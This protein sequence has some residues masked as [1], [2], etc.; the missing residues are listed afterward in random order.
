VKDMLRLFE[1]FLLLD[2]SNLKIS[3]KLIFFSDSCPGKISYKWEIKKKFSI[4]LLEDT[5]LPCDRGFG[6]ITPQ[7]TNGGQN[8][9]KIS[10]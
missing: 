7:G 9:T 5:S 8:F 6:L 10:Q 3:R 2:T 4:S 1:C